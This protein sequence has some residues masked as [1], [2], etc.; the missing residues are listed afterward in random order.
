MPSSFPDPVIL[1]LPGTS[2]PPRECDADLV[3]LIPP[4]GRVEEAGLERARVRLSQSPTLVAIVDLPAQEPTASFA[5]DLLL[6]PERVSAVLVRAE[7]LSAC[8]APVAAEG[9]LARAQV[10]ARL[11]CALEVERANSSYESVNPNKPAATMPGRISGSVI[12]LN[13]V[14]SLAP[15]SRAASSSLS[16]KRLNT[17]IIIRKPKGSVQTTCTP[18]PEEYQ[19]TG[20]PSCRISG[21]GY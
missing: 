19:A 10:A 6:H 11:A 5:L 7:A 15:I 3:L 1:E 13:T 8:S 16:S 14:H 21:I 20:M 9:S 12:S 18:R 2:I 4:G 17:A